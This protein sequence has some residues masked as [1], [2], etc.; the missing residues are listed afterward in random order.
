MT[1][2][3]GASAVSNT[4]NPPSGLPF[5]QANDYT[6]LAET[7]EMHASPSVTRYIEQEVARPSKQWILSIIDGKQEVDEVV[8]RTP[9]FVLLPDTERV[10][11]YWRA[12]R[13]L[14]PSGGLVVRSH[15]K[16]ILNWL[17]IAHDK[18]LRT[19]RDLRGRHAPMLRE[20]LDTCVSA[21]ENE[22]GIRRD[23]VMAYVHYH[24]P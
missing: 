4:I 6:L 16:R 10:N 11:R 8:C 14:P 22:T 17:A 3:S 9:D 18:Q 13:P 23:Q 21:I 7:A 19:I 20:M 2:V 12:T 1:L 24:P 5:S 15:G